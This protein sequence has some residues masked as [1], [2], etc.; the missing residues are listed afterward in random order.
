MALHCELLPRPDATAQDLRR[1]GE[2]LSR[3]LSACIDDLIEEGVE[4]DFWADLDAVDALL[5]GEQPAPFGSRCGLPGMTAGELAEAVKAARSR[6]TLPRRLL[7][8]LES[9]A[10]LFGFALPDDA[11]DS[12]VT[13]LRINLP[14][15]LVTS[16]R[17]NGV[18]YNP[19]P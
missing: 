5:A 4:A 14:L 6:Y 17:V 2:A 13:S 10:V 19:T 7:P 1:L 3:W 11:A 9:R 12:V 15:E 18:E 16:I 8:P